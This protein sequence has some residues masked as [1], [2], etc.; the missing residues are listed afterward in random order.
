[1]IGLSGKGRLA[2]V[3][4]AIMTSEPNSCKAIVMSWQEVFIGGCRIPAL[5]GLFD[6]MQKVKW[7]WL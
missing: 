1:V 5:I 6:L 3:C 7:C 4:F 2:V